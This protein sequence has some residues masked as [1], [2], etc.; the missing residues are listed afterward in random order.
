MFQLR[1]ARL[2]LKGC[3]GART[4]SVVPTPDRPNSNVLGFIAAL[5]PKVNGASLVALGLFHSISVALVPKVFGTSF[6]PLGS[7]RLILSRKNTLKI[8]NLIVL[9]CQPPNP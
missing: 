8:N 4:L 2:T 5:A 3:G 9:A 6:A 7:L 1:S